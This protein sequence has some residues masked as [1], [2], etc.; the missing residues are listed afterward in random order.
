MIDHN[1]QL[2]CTFGPIPTVV[3]WDV[4]HIATR[5]KQPDA[6]DAGEAAQVKLPPRWSAAGSRVRVRV[7]TCVIVDR[8]SR[9]ITEDVLV[10][11]GALS[12]GLEVSQVACQVDSKERKHGKK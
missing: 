7:G 4:H 6:A 10:V 9:A 11:G 8:Q 5:L 1:E 2:V 12:G 3:A